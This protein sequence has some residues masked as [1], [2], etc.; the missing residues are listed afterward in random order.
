MIR[1]RILAVLLSVVML[2][3]SCWVPSSASSTTTS[4]ITGMIGTAGST[5]DSNGDGHLGS[6]HRRLG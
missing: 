4:A 2:Q 1:L 3:L 6:C 5:S